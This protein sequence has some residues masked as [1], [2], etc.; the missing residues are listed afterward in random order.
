VFPWGD[1]WIDGKRRGPAPLK[2]VALKPG[3]YKISAG[4]ERP[5]KTKIIRVREAQRKTV[6]FD[7][8]E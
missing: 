7:L 5:S 8:T 2:N 6:Q 3:R 4:R 1:V